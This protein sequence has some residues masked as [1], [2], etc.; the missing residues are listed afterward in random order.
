MRNTKHYNGID[1]GSDAGLR[2]IE[3]TAAWMIDSA[4]QNIEKEEN[5]RLFYK[6]PSG[7]LSFESS[8]ED[9]RKMVGIVLNWG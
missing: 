8:H 4:F 1:I 5:R 6:S 9:D 2:R 3:K 7:S